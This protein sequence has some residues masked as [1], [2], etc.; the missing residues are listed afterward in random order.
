MCWVLCFS[1]NPRGPPPAMAHGPPYGARPRCDY[2]ESTLSLLESAPNT[3]DPG[4]LFPDSPKPTLR[5]CLDYFP[6]C[7]TLRAEL[8]TLPVC[9][10]LG[11][12]GDYLWRWRRRLGEQA[13]VSTFLW[14]RPLT[15]WDGARGRKRQYSDTWYLGLCLCTLALGPELLGARLP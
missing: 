13:G 15:M 12:K 4:I 3:R 1:I 6:G 8:T 5:V 10:P 11:P 2:P 7:I 9:T 14:A